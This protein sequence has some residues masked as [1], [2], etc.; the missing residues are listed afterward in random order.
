MR[1]AKLG[2]VYSVKVPNG[3]K[4][5]QWAYTIPK[6]GDFIRVFDGLYAEVP[7]NIEQIVRGPHSYIIPCYTKKMYKVGLSQLIGNYEVPKE[8]PFPEYKLWFWQDKKTNKVFAIEVMGVSSDYFETYR[9]NKMS[10]LPLKHRNETLINCYSGV[11]VILYWFDVNFNL[12]NLDL[13]TPKGDSEIAYK[14]YIDMVEAAD[15]K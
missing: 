15:R 8:Y 14:K 2:D 3:Y 13:F 9:V 5:Y 4:I 7:D 10:E 6:K 12:S 1:R 11:P